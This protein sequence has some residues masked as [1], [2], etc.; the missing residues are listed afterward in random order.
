[1]KHD[2]ALIHQFRGHR[3]IVNGIDRV[4]KSGMVFKVLNVFD[5]AGRQIVDDQNFI[6]PFQ[7]R[8]GKM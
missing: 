8:V 5:G 4:M 2:I 7:I 1:M 6:T 3:L